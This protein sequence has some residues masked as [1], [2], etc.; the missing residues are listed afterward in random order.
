MDSSPALSAIATAAANL[1]GIWAAM[2]RGFGLFGVAPARQVETA[3]W[4]GAIFCKIDRL[5]ARYRAGTLR[6]CVM[7]RVVAPGRKIVNQP[8][9]RMPR[10][11]AW[12][13]RTGK[14]H[15]AGYG[16]QLQAVLST[17]EMAGLLDVCPQAKRIL[18]PLCRA[19]AIELPWTVDKTPQ[20]RGV[21]RRRT[22][23]PRPKPEPFRIPLPRGVLSAARRQ[24]FGKMI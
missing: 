10:R 6:R 4:C 5:L 12:L 1:A 18:R 19:L 20:E 14:H 9:M 2:L 3:N 13:V 8:V 15:A 23:K 21:T 24:G 16:S 17:P 11:F 22:R 7:P